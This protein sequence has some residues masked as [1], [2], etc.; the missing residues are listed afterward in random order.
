MLPLA[1]VGTD[2]PVTVVNSVLSAYG[3]PQFKAGKG[4]STYDDFDN[5]Y[6][7]AYPRSWVARSNTQRPGIVV[8]DFN[9]A[10]KCAPSQS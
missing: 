1:L 3:L 7:F 10:D 6:L 2:D 5:E 8:S 9:T 4:F